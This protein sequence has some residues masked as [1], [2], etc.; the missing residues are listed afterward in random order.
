[1]EGIWKDVGGGLEGVRSGFKYEKVMILYEG[2][3]EGIEVGGL[4]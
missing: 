1:M 4:I 3:E 2:N